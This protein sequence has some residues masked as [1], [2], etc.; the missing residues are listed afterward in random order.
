M[1]P[2]VLLLEGGL[3]VEGCKELEG[4]TWDSLTRVVKNAL[5]PR[6]GTCF[7]SIRSY[8]TEL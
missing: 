8:Q 7:S 4:L 3:K 6:L 2:E 5:C 1:W